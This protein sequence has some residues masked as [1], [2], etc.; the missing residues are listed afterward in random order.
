MNNITS[1]PRTKEVINDYLQYEYELLERKIR[2]LESRLDKDVVNE[3]AVSIE[4]PFFINQEEIIY[5]V[6]YVKNKIKPIF[7]RIIL[8][9]CSA[10][11]DMPILIHITNDKTE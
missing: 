2:F 6:D 9:I 10:Y 4:I 8:K 1:K 11:F 7:K 5:V 3:I